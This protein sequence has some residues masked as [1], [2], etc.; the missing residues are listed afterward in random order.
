MIEGAVAFHGEMTAGN[1]EGTMD[2]GDGASARD[3]AWRE[4]VLGR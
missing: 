4:A 1:K 3:E 2:P